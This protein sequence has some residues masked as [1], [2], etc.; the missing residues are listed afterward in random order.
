MGRLASGVLL[1]ASLVSARLNLGPLCL[2]LTLDRV[3]V[4]FTIFIYILAGIEIYQKRRQLR[5][6]SHPGPLE[7]VDNPFI[8][9]KTTKIEVTSEPAESRNQSEPSLKTENEGIGVLP[10]RQY[11][12]YSITIESGANAMKS[13]RIERPRTA[14]E[15]NTAAW[16]Y[17]RIAFL[18]FIALLITW[19]SPA[20]MFLHEPN[21]S[22]LLVPSPLPRNLL[23]RGKLTY[24]VLAGSIVS[25]PSL[26]IGPP[27]QTE[28]RTQLRRL[29]RSASPRF[30]ERPYL[31][32]HFSPRFSE[33][34][35]T[36]KGWLPFTV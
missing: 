25:Q 22:S 5:Q 13:P 18:F 16:G 9:T 19:V 28:F 1:W 32:H 3:V 30:L 33:S 20:M 35:A 11:M 14:L 27:R 34:P 29:S 15:A 8:S 4:M 24:N 10:S 6:F 2:Y 12:E 21:A 7:V 17:T 36:D 23:P 26:C 31:L